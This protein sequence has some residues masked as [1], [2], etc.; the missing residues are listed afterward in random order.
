LENNRY[1]EAT[2]CSQIGK[3]PGIYGAGGYRRLNARASPLTRRGRPRERYRI[4]L[5]E[6]KLTEVMSKLINSR[7][8]EHADETLVIQSFCLVEK[9]YLN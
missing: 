9:K 8:E 4:D 7:Q 5:F 1:R 6:M 2:A 3:Y